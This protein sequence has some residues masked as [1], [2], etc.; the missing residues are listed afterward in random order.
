MMK[1][2]TASSIREDLG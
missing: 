1:N 2:N